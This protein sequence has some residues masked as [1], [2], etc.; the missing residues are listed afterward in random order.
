MAIG[1]FSGQDLSSVRCKI[2][3][4]FQKKRI[5]ERT[6]LYVY[7]FENFILYHLES[8]RREGKGEGFYLVLEV[9]S[10]LAG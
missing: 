2:K 1:V 4:L 7:Y 3:T 8:W 6:E 5:N 9:F 10:G